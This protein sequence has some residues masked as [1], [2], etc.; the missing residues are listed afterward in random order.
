MMGWKGVFLV[1]LALGL[2]M[3]AACSR[4]VP[5]AEYDKARADL[6][7]AQGQTKGLETQL[8]PAK[9]SL[10]KANADLAQAKSDSDKAKADLAT[11]QARVQSLQ[12]DYTSVVAERDRARND[13]VQVRADSDKAKADL[14]AAPARAGPRGGRNPPG[15][16]PPSRPILGLRTCCS[17]TPTD[18]NSGYSRSTSIPTPS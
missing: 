12:N 5:Q 9:A 13:L 1:T 10:D 15:P 4:G 17:W 18:S 11:A 14:P 16:W 6:A 8:G 3:T 2:L 7:A